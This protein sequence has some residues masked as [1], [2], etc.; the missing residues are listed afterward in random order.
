MV[1]DNLCDYC[2]AAWNL[3]KP[4]QVI[5]KQEIVELGKPEQIA[6][7]NKAYPKDNITT[8]DLNQYQKQAK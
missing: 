1:I 8:K 5:S 3:L 4:T 7:W 6:M 2:L